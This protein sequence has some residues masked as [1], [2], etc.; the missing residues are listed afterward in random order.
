MLIVSRV[1]LKALADLAE[2]SFPAEACALLIG[3]RGPGLH[4][5]ITRVEPS[6]N[7]AADPGRGFEIDPGL[8]IGL[9]RELRR[10]LEQ[11]VGVW[12][13]HPNG[14]PEPSAADAAMIFEPDL[15]W[16]IT[17]VEQGQALQTEAY[18]PAA[19]RGAGSRVADG[20][21]RIE[22]ILAE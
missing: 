19:G 2:A 9:Q 20:F 4:Y 16:L 18:V 12:H 21:R 6:R 3:R 17:A 5:R 14:R 13:S 7:Q 8:R 1:H 11:I 10:G 22:L 15:C